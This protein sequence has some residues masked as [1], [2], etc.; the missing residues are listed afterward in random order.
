MATQE[1]G[2]SQETQV[3]VDRCKRNM[4]LW[5]MLIVVCGLVGLY[6]L[7]TAQ[8]VVLDT[9]ILSLQAERMPLGVLAQMRD[10]PRLVVDPH[11]V[12]RWANESAIIRSDELFG[13]PPVKLIGYD[14][15][16]FIPDYALAKHHSG[17]VRAESNPN[18]LAE[19][20][21]RRMHNFTCDLQTPNGLVPAAM[22]LA[23]FKRN[24]ELWYVAKIEK[25]EKPVEKIDSVGK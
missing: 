13:V 7:P 16:K 23:Q 1:A 24:G 6:A 21:S 17:K 12:V 25:V 9:R 4:Q 15:A 14:A 3:I 22:E 19:G 11:M 10:D 8:D 20:E 18:K 2:L 5:L